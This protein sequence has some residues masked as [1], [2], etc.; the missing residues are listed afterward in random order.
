MKAKQAGGK[1]HQQ[2]PDNGQ[3][4]S[5]KNGR[6]E[7]KK[8]HFVKHSFLLLQITAT[9][10]KIGQQSLPIKWCLLR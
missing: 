10:K 7:D 4:I 3:F 2:N 6:W 9:E 5:Y 1:V 8:L